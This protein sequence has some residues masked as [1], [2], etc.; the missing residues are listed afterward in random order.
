VDSPS[1][2][3]VGK[4]KAL[5]ATLGYPVFL[6][7]EWTM[8]WETLKPYHQDPA[9]FVPNV[10]GTIIAWC[11]A[12]T[13]WLENDENEKAVEKLLDALKGTNRLKL[14]LEVC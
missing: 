13:L 4:T 5:T 7:P 2:Q 3:L 11:D 6:D 1:S 14:L 9:T 12:F 8:L 10:S